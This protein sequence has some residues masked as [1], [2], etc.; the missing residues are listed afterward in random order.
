MELDKDTEKLVTDAT[1]VLLM[2]AM[3]EALLQ[4]TRELE[5]SFE[6]TSSYKEYL[7]QAVRDLERTK[8]L[9]EN[10]EGSLS[11]MLQDT[12]VAKGAEN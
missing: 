4:Q 7:V 3:C 5:K 11:T 10:I 6:A 9:I 8:S 1:R 12:P 2:G